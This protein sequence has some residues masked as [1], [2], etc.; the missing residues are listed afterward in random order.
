[1]KIKRRILPKNSAYSPIPKICDE[2]EIIA[3]P[4]KFIKVDYSI[5]LSDLTNTS[6]SMLSY[7]CYY[8]MCNGGHRYL[9]FFKEKL[10]P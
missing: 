7:L 2:A 4:F 1:M 10:T 9:I 3:K 6:K 5:V 8:S